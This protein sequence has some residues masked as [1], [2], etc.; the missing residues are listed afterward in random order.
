VPGLSGDG[1]DGV[2]GVISVCRVSPRLAFMDR[3]M[4]EP[5]TV[6]SRVGECAQRP[7]LACVRARDLPGMLDPGH[8]A[9]GRP[10]ES[11]TRADGRGWLVPPPD[12]RQNVNRCYGGVGR[13]GN[14]LHRKISS[15]DLV[16]FAK[17]Q[18]PRSRGGDGLNTH[19]HR[20]ADPTGGIRSQT[21]SDR[22]DSVADRCPGGR[23]AG[24][25]IW[26]RPGPS[27]AGH[28]SARPTHT[29]RRG[30]A[31]LGLC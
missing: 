6:D 11:P 30:V 23:P 15:G 25:D 7:R 24:P 26:H 9:S 19:G 18:S 22:G 8:R 5:S 4:D 14:F 20:P 3:S 1:N 2:V 27:G 28:P 29:N 13:C 21:E 16:Q 12:G 31:A 10:P 17:S